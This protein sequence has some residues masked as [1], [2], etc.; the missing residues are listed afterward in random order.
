MIKFKFS[1]VFL[2]FILN[3]LSYAQDIKVLSS[4]ASSIVI[5]YRPVYSDTAIVKTQTQQYLK[6]DLLGGYVENYRSA[7]LPQEQ[8]REINIGVPSEFG[9]TIQVLSSEFSNLSGRYLP[10][11]ELMKDSVSFVKKYVESSKYNVQMKHDLVAFGEFGLVR[12]FPVQSIKIYPIQ[13]DPNTNSSRL[14]KRLIFKINFA[15]PATTRQLIQDNTLDGAVLNWNV[16]RNWGVV[17]KQRMAKMPNS[18]LAAGDWYRFETPTEGIYKIDQTF[19]QGLGIDAASVDPRT[20]KIYGYGGYALPENLAVSNNQGLTENA[21]YVA[22]ESDGKF[23]AADY[24][25]FYGRP[26]EFW[27]YNKSLKRI[28]RVKNPYNKKNYYWLTYGGANGKRMAPKQSLNIQ[29]AYVQPFTQ[30]FKSLDK[31]SI[32]IG[33]SGRDYFGDVLDI[34]TK[35][36]TYLTSLNGILPSSSIRYKFRQVNAS[37]PIIPFNVQESGVQIYNSNLFGNSDYIYGVADSGSAVYNGTLA[38][39][40]ST[41]KFAINTGSASAKVYLDYF[42]I[43]YKK[44]LRAVS[45]NLLFFSKDTTATIEYDLSNFS[46]SSIQTFDITDFANVQLVSGASISGGQYKFQES[47]LN[48]AVHKYYAVTSSAFLTPANGTKMSNSNI[49]G[50]V[51]GSEMIVITSRNFQTQAERYAAYRSSQSPYKLSTQIFY[52]DDIMNEFDGGLLDPTAIRD[53]LKYAYDNWQIKPFY[54]LLF[55]DGTYDYLNSEKLNNN[56]VPTY[57]T[58]ESLDEIYSYPMDDY[59]ARISGNDSKADLAIGRLPIDTEDDA[60]SVVDKIIAYETTLDKG[61][62]RN[63]V[64]LVADDGPQALGVDDGSIHTS[65]SENLAKNKLPKYFDQNKIYLVAYPTVYTGLG[66]RKPGVNQAMIDAIN[67]GT[68]IFNY[69][70]H[71]NPEVLAHEVVFDKKVSIPQIKNDKY[72]FLTAATCDFGKYDDPT[73]QSSAEMMLTMP[74]AGEIAAFTAARVVFSTSNAAINDSLYTNLFRAREANNLPITIGKAFFLTKQFRVEGN[75]EKFHLFGDPSVRLDEPI[76]PA[77]ID[78]VN[79]K[80]LQTNVQI[81]ALD[82]VKINGSVRNADGS[83][84][85]FNGEAIISVFDSEQ[86]RYFAEMN[87]TVTFPG[88]LIYRG[89]VTIN[90][91]DFQTEFVV[92][93]DI[94]YENKNGKIVAYVY[95]N[96]TDGVGYTRNIIVGGTNPNAVNDGKGPDISIY[97]DNTNFANSYL[98]NPDFTLIAKLTDHNGLNTTGTGIGHK[99]EGIVN[100]AVSKTIDFT[101]YFVGDLNSGGKSGA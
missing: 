32:N 64:T 50:N 1:L 38:D 28:V 47:E 89:R 20:I 58:P 86:S 40:R 93:K 88:G 44:Y 45:D 35:S 59:Y 78:S 70:G 52:V 14:I 41:L 10:T 2:F 8:V 83:K 22:G 69:V 49:R 94:S 17:Q 96:S 29:N 77:K 84:N 16:A 18:V 30:A 79:G 61:L 24:V 53:F 11:P 3:V 34:D 13:F 101:N 90:N 39:E 7:G 4:D 65:Q 33:K 21:I 19:L 55:G 43:V 87:Y 25:L 99:L 46:N 74:N 60:K 98:V 100:G 91:G 92:P 26:P 42:E 71:G 12:N 31:D 68:L 57:Q 51:A 62:W 36:R 76:V 67:N 85:Q 27:E 6:L 63:T 97:F 75:D 66:R 9:N 72:F 80:T 54:V 81:S 15:P 56:F 5:E 23:D 48:G 95:N 82:T 73:N 37:S